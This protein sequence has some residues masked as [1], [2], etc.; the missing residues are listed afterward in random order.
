MGFAEISFSP[1][2]LFEVAPMRKFLLAFAFLAAVGLA[3]VTPRQASAGFFRGGYYTP[4]Y[5]GAGYY[6]PSYT[7]QPNYYGGYYPNYY[8][9]PYVGSYYTP[10]YGA[11]SYYEN[12]SYSPYYGPRYDRSFAVYAPGGYFYRR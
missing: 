9:T 2:T 4:S 1:L 12:Y 5:Y 7:Y 6:V 10:Y 11:S 3:V 8:G